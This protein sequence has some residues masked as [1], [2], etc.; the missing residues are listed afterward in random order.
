MKLK[1]KPYHCNNHPVMGVLVKGENPCDWMMEIQ[2][3]KLSLEA[4]TVYAIP[5]LTANSVWGCFLALKN[6]QN[7]L[8]IG[9]N[10]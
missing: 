2:R 8:D 5:G 3:M 6:N 9:K 10:C 7:E 1:I 4:I